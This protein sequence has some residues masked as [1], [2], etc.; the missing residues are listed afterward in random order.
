[1]ADFPVVCAAI[2]S[3]FRISTVPGT[4]STNIKEEISRLRVRVKTETSSVSPSVIHS[5]SDYYSNV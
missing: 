4:G 3:D 5:L 2:F 1:M